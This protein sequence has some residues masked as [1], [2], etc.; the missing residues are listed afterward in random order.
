MNW[1]LIAAVIVGL[2]TGVLLYFWTESVKNEQVAYAFMRL[3]PD[4]KVTRGQAITPDMLAEPVMLPESFGALAKLAVPAASAYQEWLKDRTAAADIP[5][6]SVL[7]FQYFDDNDGGRLT[8]M[9]A[10]GKR[11]LTL[12]VNAAAAVG[13]FVE[14]GSYVDILGTVDEPVEPVAP[15]AATQPGAPA[16]P[17][18]APVAA[19]QP[20]APVQ[21]ASPVEQM[22]KNYLTQ[23]PGA[24]ENDV[25]AYRKQAQ[26]Y[27]LGISS[28]T[29]VVT[30]TFLQNVK[31]LA[32]GA[33]TTAEGAVTKANSTYNNVTVEVTPAEAE[34]LIFALGQSNGSLNLVL[35]NPADNTVEELPSINWTRM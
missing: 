19:G 29:R 11:A 25:N 12:P 35:R 23:Y 13:H 3:Q 22:L 21:P 6:G 18:Q 10:P 17:G 24:D 34:M 14:P 7:L 9:I 31:V 30:R 28:R 26:D 33:A 16:A 1:K 32:V 2:I 27:K 5:A 8:T 4:R 15:P 20:Q